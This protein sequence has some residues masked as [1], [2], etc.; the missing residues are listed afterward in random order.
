MIT[1]FEKRTA[2]ITEKEKNLVPT[3]CASFRRNHVGKENLISNSQ[4]RIALQNFNGTKLAEERLRIIIRY[5][6]M[7]N[8]VPCLC[9]NG[10][11]Y[12]VATKKTEME[13]NI[14]SLREQAD[15]LYELAKVLER[16]YY[17]NM[18]KLI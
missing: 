14:E 18:E 7:N 4:I 13:K 9:A 3:I 11:G 6:R 12:F 1:N 15:T 5:I 17:D 16:Q 2:S 10:R 8:L